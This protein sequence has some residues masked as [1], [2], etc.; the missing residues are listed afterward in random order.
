MANEKFRDWVA[1]EQS[2]IMGMATTSN[3]I[4]DK[5]CKC[6]VT[7]AKKQLDKTRGVIS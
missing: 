7:W 3:F 6:N 5:S 1:N 4:A 2:K